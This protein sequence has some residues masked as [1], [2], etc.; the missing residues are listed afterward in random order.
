METVKYIVGVMLI[1]LA[2]G[3]GSGIV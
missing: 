1:A 3:L 2:L